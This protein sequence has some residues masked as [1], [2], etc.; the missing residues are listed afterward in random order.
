MHCFPVISLGTTSKSYATRNPAWC[1]FS[2]A[3]GIKR[4]TADGKQPR[5][6][7]G[8]TVLASSPY[9]LAQPRRRT[10]MFANTIRVSHHVRNASLLRVGIFSRKQFSVISKPTSFPAT[11]YRF[12]TQRSSGLLDYEESGDVENGVELSADGL[13][14]PK[15]SRNPSCRYCILSPSSPGN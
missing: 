9:V 7:T 13:I 1:W 15:V 12:Q 14:R 10:A 2:F 11:L 4:R 5:I 6:M 3:A 8:T